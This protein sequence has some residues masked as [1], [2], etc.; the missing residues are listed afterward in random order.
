MYFARKFGRPHF[1]ILVAGPELANQIHKFF[2]N[3]LYTL[4][5]FIDLSEVFDTVNYSI[6]F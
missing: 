2:E 1:Q 4:G 5:A 6:F 3:N